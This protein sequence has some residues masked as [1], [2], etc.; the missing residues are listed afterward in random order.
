[1]KQQ[2]REFLQNAGAELDGE[3][4]GS[5]GNPERELQVAT[6]GTV[7]SDLSHLGLISAHGADAAAYLQGQL[8]C[9]VREVTAQ[10]SRLG[11]HCTHKG[12]AQALFRLFKRGDSYYLQLPAALVDESIQR[13]R[14][15]V[16]M[17]KITLEDAGDALVRFGYA[18]PDAAA[19][20]QEALG[21]VPSE[22]DAVV[23]TPDLLAIRLPGI[24][25][26]FELAG[27]L[28]AAQRLWQLLDVHA[29]PVGAA[30]WGLLDVLAGLP[31]V[32]P[33]TVETFVPQMLNL[34]AIGGVSF[35]KGCYT[36]QEVVARTEYLGKLKRRMYL[37]H[38][39][40]ER[41]PR[42]GEALYAPDCQ[43]GQG[44]GTVVDAQPYPDGGF[45]LLAVI[46]S[47]SVDAGG[48]RLGDAHGPPLE[49]RELPYPLGAENT[50]QQ[51]DR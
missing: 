18:G 33:E 34:H 6:T 50:Q 37:G 5:F 43:S 35:I 10:R 48:V 32:Y 49:I 16:L 51:V 24:H 28:E 27:E 40:G 19:H 26:R 46:Q 11:A 23:Q 14:K 15:Y 2:W 9:D 38:V 29:A 20:L 44:T 21:A 30:P 13:L 7:L 42:P 47:A 36:G 8:T 22:V 4:V 17:S 45:E 3:C 25:P 1:M 39:G 12:R 31:N 41:L